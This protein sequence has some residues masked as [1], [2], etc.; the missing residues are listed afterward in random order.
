MSWQPAREPD[1]TLKGDSPVTVVVD[2]H[3]KDLGGFTVRRALPSAKARMVGPFI[4]LDAM[5]PAEFLTGQGIDVRPHPHIGLATVTWLFGGEILHRDSVGS[6]QAIRPGEM[7]WMTAGRGIAHSERTAPERRAVPHG[8]FG[9]QA[10]VALPKAHEEVE[11]GFEHVPA[12]AMPGVE[13]GGV[14]ARVI[15][16]E[17]WGARSPVKALHPTI[18][19]EVVLE[20][21]AVLPVDARAA[22]E[23]A[24]YLV[25][26]EVE[27]AGDR[28]GPWKLLL[29]RPGEDVA[30]RAVRPSRLMLLGGA[31][32]DGPRHIWWNFVSSSAERIEQAKEDWTAGRFGAVPAESEWI[33]LPK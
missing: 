33:P 30:V 20:A 7:N 1:C 4:F 6:V 5:G 11:P 23:R 19:A 15:A 24:I 32:M 2:P 17:L 10:W 18:Y 22:E 8:L 31:A 3:A 26:G 25:E 21:G 27:I 9:V 13:D 16:G 28:F 14:R 29:F 12:E